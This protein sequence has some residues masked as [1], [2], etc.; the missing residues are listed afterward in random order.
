MSMHMIFEKIIRLLGVFICLLS[1]GCVVNYFQ[2]EHEPTK[3]LLKGVSI[4]DIEMSEELPFE[5]VLFVPFF[6]KLTISYPVPESYLRVYSL[7]K[8]DVKVQS[9]VLI[10]GSK[11]NILE[12]NKI[13]TLK[14]SDKGYFSGG[15][16]LFD[17]DKF[18]VSK[19][20][21]GDFVKLKVLLNIDGIDNELVFLLKLV[22]YSDIAWST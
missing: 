10:N 1:T 19:L 21:K 14:K 13:V 8:R 9:A 2:L 6:N 18:D 22:E 17:S 12:L 20:S 15:I 16:K 5:N 11:K 7:E 3:R 4:S